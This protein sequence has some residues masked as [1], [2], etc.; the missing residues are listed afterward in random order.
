MALMAPSGSRTPCK[1]NPCRSSAAI[2]A[3]VVVQLHRRLV[4]DNVACKA[5]PSG[6][7]IS[8]PAREATEPGGRSYYA[9]TAQGLTDPGN[10]N[11][12]VVLLRYF[13]NDFVVLEKHQLHIGELQA[14]P[15]RPLL[16]ETR[17]TTT[18]PAGLIAPHLAVSSTHGNVVIGPFGQVSLAGL[19]PRGDKAISKEEWEDPAAQEPG[20]TTNE[21]SPW[22]LER[23]KVPKVHIWVSL[24]LFA[25]PMDG[26]M[27][28]IPLLSPFL[29]PLLC[30]WPPAAGHAPRQAAS[31]GSSDH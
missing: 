10:S 11:R 15:S 13:V 3:V 21:E 14:P 7:H 16:N 20:A 30:C 4:A 22:T 17:A 27:R 1:S 18:T 25:Y 5:L 12:F 28:K 2:L 8:I 19:G 9:V 26:E 31:H 6:S 29:S 24:R 23:E